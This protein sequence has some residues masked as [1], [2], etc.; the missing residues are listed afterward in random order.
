MSIAV[1]DKR[2]TNCS[3]AMPALST[4]VLFA[5]FAQ[6]VLLPRSLGCQHSLEAMV[7]KTFFFVECCPYA[8]VCSSQSWKKAGVWGESEQEAR[9]AVV[10][11]LVNSGHHKL[12]KADAEAMAVIVPVDSYE[13][14][15]DEEQQQ[16]QAKKAR[17]SGLQHS[18]PS[19]T[20]TSAGGLLAGGL[21]QLPIGMGGLEPLSSI[22][23]GMVRARPMPT[24]AREAKIYMRAT[25]FQAAID[26]T[27]RA[28]HAAEQAQRLSL[29][30]S[31]AFADEVSALTAVHQN[32]SSIR[33]TADFR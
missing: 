17:W 18:A 33:D 32:L 13:E 28:L 19:A 5:A 15:V 4:C 31:R 22:S 24:A 29:A 2:A 27:L 9:N 16:H 7:K 30:A 21:Q 6:A 26:C 8:E 1:Q 11:H 25:E 20:A 10:Q 12:S 3:A 14:E 23:S